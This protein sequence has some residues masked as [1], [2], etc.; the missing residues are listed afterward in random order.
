M[1]INHNVIEDVSSVEPADKKLIYTHHSDMETLQQC[2]D[3][4]SNN[5]CK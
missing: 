4:P 1:D 5:M 2:F 3:M